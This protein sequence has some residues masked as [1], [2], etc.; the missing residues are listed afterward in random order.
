MKHLI[1]LFDARKGSRID[2]FWARSY[3]YVVNFDLFVFIEGVIFQKGHS[4]IKVVVCYGDSRIQRFLMISS[5]LHRNF[6][7]LNFFYLVNKTSTQL[8]NLDPGGSGDE[9]YIKWKAWMSSLR[10]YWLERESLRKW[11][12][13]DAFKEWA[14]K[15]FSQVAPHV[16]K[17]YILI[18]FLCFS[19][20]KH[21]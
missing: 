4:Y 9:T 2:L 16:L 7:F 18:W 20:R 19:I 13:N 12:W 3:I 6:Q 10:K 17:I 15:K 21:L 1:Y 8:L 14:R 5:H 11:G